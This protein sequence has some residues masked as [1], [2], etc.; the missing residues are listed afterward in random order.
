MALRLSI[1]IGF[2]TNSSSV[3]HH[4]P[5]ELFNDV[6]VKAFLDAFEVHGGFVG[7]DLW[8]RGECATVA[9]TKEQKEE[10]VRK[11]HG[12]GYEEYNPPGIT[13]TDDSVVIIY[14]DEHQSLAMSLAGLLK[15]VA[16]ELGIPT[17]GQD[18][19]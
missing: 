18:Y 8:H 14:G 5:R 10:A 12:D 1:N 6:R 17:G 7:T 4:F 15:S 11:L 13:T 16:E 19:N 2:I 3:V 9:M